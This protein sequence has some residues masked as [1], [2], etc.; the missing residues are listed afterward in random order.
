MNTGSSYEQ[1]VGFDMSYLPKLSN[2]KERDNRHTLL[3]FLVK[4]I[5]QNHPDDLSFMV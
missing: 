3:H 2:T 1:S 4:E 5:M